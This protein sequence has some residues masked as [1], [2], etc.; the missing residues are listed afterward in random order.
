METI[1]ASGYEN[2]V[3]GIDSSIT[4]D[5]RQVMV[6]KVV[7]F[8]DDPADGLGFLDADGPEDYKLIQISVA[9]GGENIVS[10]EMVMTP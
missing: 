1:I 6:T 9:F 8:V 7:S 3:S 10:L 4:I 2:A 5:G